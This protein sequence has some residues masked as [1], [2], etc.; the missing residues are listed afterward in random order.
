M[1]DPS[2]IV[3]IDAIP[4]VV[5]IRPDVRLTT[6]HG[7][8]DSSAYVLVKV[9]T[10]GGHVGLG[11]ATV[12]PLWNGEDSVTALQCIRTYLA[13]EVIGV[14][15][16]AIER[17]ERA[18]ERRTKAHPFAKAA[19]E[20]ACWDLAGRILGVPVSTLLGG[21]VRERIA[22]KFVVTATTPDR[23]AELARQAVAQGF[24]TLK[25][26][27]GLQVE[28]DIARVHAVRAAVGPAIKITVDANGG[29]SVPAAIAA[30]RRMEPDRLTLVEQP[31][32]PGN[33]LRLA[34]VRRAV[35]TPIMADESVFT[36]ADAALLV[37]TGAAD[38]FSLYP[39]KHGGLL[40]ARKL[41]A[42]AEVNGLSASVG[43]N[44]ELGI[45]SAAMAHL[46]AATPAIDADRYPTDIIGPLYHEHDVVTDNRFI[47]RGYVV[48][49]EGAGLG[50]TLDEAA[51]REYRVREDVR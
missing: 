25:V 20:M 48:A 3:A 46:A 47:Q 6:A 30:I 29:W 26:K 39:G 27:V 23:A 51:V 31:V 14:S 35:G 50:V 37:Q 17:I 15:P 4:V 44:L 8:R 5:P 13:P 11:E 22:T 12:D 33:P 24:Q 28:E 9:T 32:A 2:T 1:L 7:T 34:E 40:P 43:S 49:P 10:A 38:V 21:K 18:M 45:A 42:F 19:V 36:F 41:A 16:L